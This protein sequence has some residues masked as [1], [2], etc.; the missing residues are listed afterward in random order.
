MND[1]FNELMQFKKS[2]LDYMALK[3]IDFTTA[4][5]EL[6]D[7][8]RFSTIDDFGRMNTA[9]EE[10]RRLSILHN[11]AKNF[12]KRLEDISTGITL[13]SDE[14]QIAACVSAYLIL[15]STD[16]FRIVE[17]QISTVNSKENG[18]SL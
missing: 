17:E 15:K 1:I 14:K 6:D 2:I 4:K 9:F 10:M 12:W 16:E 18:K 13:E 7:V 8:S 3:S 11:N 5:E